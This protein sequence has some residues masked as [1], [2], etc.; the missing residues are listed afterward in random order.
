MPYYDMD[1]S[2]GGGRRQRKNY[3]D[4]PPSG[5]HVYQEL[6]KSILW[7]I[8]IYVS[9]FLPHPWPMLWLPFDIWG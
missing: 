8:W 3:D 6:P 1:K 2:R 5:S 4:A 9:V 7:W